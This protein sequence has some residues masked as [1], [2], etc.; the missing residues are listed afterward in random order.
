[1]LHEWQV[2]AERQKVILTI[3]AENQEAEPRK[4]LP[5][6]RVMFWTDVT[7]DGIEYFHFI[8]Y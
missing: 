7:L 6:N 4:D 1:M 8:I 3:R 2:E 5:I